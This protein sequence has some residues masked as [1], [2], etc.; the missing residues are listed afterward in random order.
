MCETKEYKGVNL[1]PNYHADNFLKV[2]KVPKL[3]RFKQFSQF[4]VWGINKV[5]VSSNIAQ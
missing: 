5:R 1:P 2:S 4:E 3:K